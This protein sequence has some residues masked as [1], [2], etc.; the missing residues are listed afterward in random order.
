MFQVSESECIEIDQTVTIVFIN[1]PNQA[2]LTNVVNIKAV[3]GT[4]RIF[5]YDLTPDEP[6]VPV[7]SI[8][9]INTLK[10][11][12]VNDGK[13]E[14]CMSYFESLN[15]SRCEMDQIKAKSSRYS[16]IFVVLKNEEYVNLVSCLR[17]FEFL[18]TAEANTDDRVVKLC[19]VEEGVPLTEGYEWNELAEKFFRSSRKGNLNLVSTRWDMYLTD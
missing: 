18:P 9:E 6:P 8:R 3:R 2:H 1:H 15:L 13:T 19:N 16:H 4:L 10:V 5:G 7:F 14:H 12:T 17:H 11:I